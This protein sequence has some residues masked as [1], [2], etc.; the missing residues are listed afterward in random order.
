MFGMDQ[1][2]IPELLNRIHSESSDMQ[3]C[4]VILIATKKYWSGHV[5]YLLICCCIAS[6]L[7]SIDTIC[8]QQMTGGGEV[9]E[10]SSA[11]C[12]RGKGFLWEENIS[13]EICSLWF[14]VPES[15]SVKEWHAEWVQCCMFL[16]LY[17]PETPTSR[18][19]TDPLSSV[20]FWRSIINDGDVSRTGIILTEEHSSILTLRPQLVSGHYVLIFV[21]TYNDFF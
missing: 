10:G 20:R 9:G 16:R 15:V 5:I 17:I 7:V 3:L 19:S 11:C 18:Q 21:K 14:S 1:P 4:C 2:I 13:W 6:S 8:L 12:P